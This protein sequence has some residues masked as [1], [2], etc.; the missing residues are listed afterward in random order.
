MLQTGLHLYPDVGVQVTSYTVFPFTTTHVLAGV[1]FV[2]VLRMPAFAVLFFMI[3]I[4]KAHEKMS[5]AAAVKSL[6]QLI[7]IKFFICER[8]E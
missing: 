5:I 3:N 1:E 4:K 7:E 8:F 2:S 6:Y